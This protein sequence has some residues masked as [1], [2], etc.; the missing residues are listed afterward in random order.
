MSGDSKWERFLEARRNAPPGFLEV[1]FELPP[2]RLP[3]R[4][5]SMWA[6][7]VGPDLFVLRNSPFH[8]DGVSFLDTVRAERRGP[9]WFF[10]EV[11]ARSGHST[12]RVR[13]ADGSMREPWSRV[14]APLKRLGCTIEKANQRWSAIDI[15][16]SAD[17]HAVV[18]ALRRGEKEGRWEVEDAHYGH[19]MA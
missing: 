5:E 2:E 11:Y 1:T 13:L 15:P 19:P 12:F 6:Q 9:E 10:V 16:P 17:V 18:M 8:A 3:W 4:T 14:V 7:Q